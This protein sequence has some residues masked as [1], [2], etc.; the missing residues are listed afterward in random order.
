[1]ENRLIFTAKG[2]EVLRSLFEDMI[3]G[4]SSIVKAHVISKLKKHYPV[5]LKGFTENQ[6][7]SRIRTQ[8]RAYFRK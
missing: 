2:G 8:R 1:M 5:M 6:I 3:V 7:L 4:K